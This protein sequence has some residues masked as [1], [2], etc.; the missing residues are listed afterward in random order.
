MSLRSLPTPWRVAQTFFINQEVADFYRIDSILCLADAKHIREHLN[1]R[2][3]ARAH[4]RHAAPLT[5]PGANT[6]A[7]GEAGGR[8]E[9]GGAAGGVR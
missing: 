4:K 3:A 5:R 8:G 6:R 1:V 7:G 2:R 9:R